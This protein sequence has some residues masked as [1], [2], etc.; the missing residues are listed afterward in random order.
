MKK[1]QEMNFYELL[2]IEPTAQSEEEQ[3]IRA[4]EQAARDEKLRLQLSGAGVFQEFPTQQKELTE[5]IGTK[6]RLE[7]LAEDTRKEGFIK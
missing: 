6:K 1:V 4:E 3:Q 2:D 5:G 7:Q